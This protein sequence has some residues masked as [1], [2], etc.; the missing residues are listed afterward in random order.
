MGR[1]RL[2]KEFS[3]EMAHS[4]FGHD[5]LCKN[6]HGHSY[7]LFVTVI[8]EPIVEVGNPKRGMVIDFSDLK[9]IVKS[10]IVDKLDHALM[11][12]N[13]TEHKKIK[14]AL[15]GIVSMRIIDV[16]YQT[17]CENMVMDFAEIIK[18]K[19]PED[20]DLHSL[21]LYETATSFAEWYASDNLL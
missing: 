9:K 14:K 18:Q 7:R 20:V 8:G 6:I 12:N 16:P 19:L 3:F 1:I 17:T 13:T 5:G 10:E 4:L 15:E 2:T 11:I 21:K